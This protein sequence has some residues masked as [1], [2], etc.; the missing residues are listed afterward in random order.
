MC[1]SFRSIRSCF[2]LFVARQTKTK[3]KAAGKY[4]IA[5]ICIGVSPLLFVRYSPITFGVDHARTTII[6]M[7]M[8]C[9]VNADLALEVIPTESSESSSIDGSANATTGNSSFS[10]NEKLPQEENNK[11]IT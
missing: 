8:T 11:F 10:D 9:Q 3:V 4:L 6:N 7:V 2:P 1:F 5:L